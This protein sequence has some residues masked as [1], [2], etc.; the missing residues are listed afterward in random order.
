M[1]FELTSG[2]SNFTHNM[3][4]MFFYTNCKV[5]TVIWG[6]CSSYTLYHLRRNYGNTYINLTQVTKRKVM[7]NQSSS[8]KPVDMKPR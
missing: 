5:I 4:N 2:A 3:A 6:S 7:L 8:E 1:H